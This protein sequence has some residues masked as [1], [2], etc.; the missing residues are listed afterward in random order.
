MKNILLAILSTLALSPLANAQISST[1]YIPT[2]FDFAAQGARVSLLT[3]IL[4]THLK[5]SGENYN[6]EAETNTGSIFGLSFGYAQLPIRSLGFM[7]D[8]AVFS[9]SEDGNES[10]MGRLSGNLAYSFNSKFYLKGGL[11]VFRFLNSAGNMTM[12][13]GFGG[14]AGIGAQM[15]PNLGIETSYV[16]MKTSSEETL[17]DHYNQEHKFDVS[18]TLS[19]LE[20][21]VTAT[22]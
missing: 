15:T 5:V 6:D 2:S 20:I 22:F 1:T 19:G 4:S 16:V 17:Y 12:K 18:A 3:P 13:P 9:L 7:A 10:A 11:N 14:Q 8:F 21:A